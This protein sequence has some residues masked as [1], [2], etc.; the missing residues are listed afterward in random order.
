MNVEM[1]KLRNEE[2]QKTTAEERL[3]K[4]L[5]DFHHMKNEHMTVRK[6]GFFFLFYEKWF[7]HTFVNYLCIFLLAV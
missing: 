2:I 5:H 1:N 4:T 7:I 3:E 6:T